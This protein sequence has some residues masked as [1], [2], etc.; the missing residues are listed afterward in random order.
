MPLRADPLF[1]RTGPDDRYESSGPQDRAIA[2]PPGPNS[3]RVA[4]SCWPPSK[5][6]VSGLDGAGFGYNQAPGIEAGTFFRLTFL[7]P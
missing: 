7:M 2:A 3:W 4:Y 6:Y 1:G 5:K